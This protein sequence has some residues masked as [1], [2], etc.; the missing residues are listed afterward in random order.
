MSI[1]IASKFKEDK[2][3]SNKEYA[4]IGG[5]LP[6]ELNY[7]EHVFLRGIRFHLHVELPL[8]MEYANSLFGRFSVLSIPPTNSIY[9]GEGVFGE[10]IEGNDPHFTFSLANINKA[11]QNVC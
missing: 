7:M 11:P 9:E 3:L 4:E 2:F 1:V 6:K 8:Y 5:V 10:Q